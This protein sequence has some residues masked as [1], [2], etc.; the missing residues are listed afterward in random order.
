MASTSQPP[1]AAVYI[2]KCRTKGCKTALRVNDTADSCRSAGSVFAWASEGRDASQPGVAYCI[3]NYG[4]YARCGEHGLYP[5][6]S[7]KGR[8]VAEKGCDARCMGATGPSCDCSCGGANHG[9]NHA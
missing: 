8:Y 1:A 2:G 9:A 4:A 5:L 6:R 3:G 7:L